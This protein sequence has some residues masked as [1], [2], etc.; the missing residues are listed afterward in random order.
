MLCSDMELELLK[1]RKNDTTR[2]S[3]EKMLPFV[4]DDEEDETLKWSKSTTEAARKIAEDAGSARLGIGD[5]AAK[6]IREVVHTFEQPDLNIWA[7]KPRSK[8]RPYLT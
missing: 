7:S 3:G 5:D 2:V 1:A 8:V 6:L 4:L